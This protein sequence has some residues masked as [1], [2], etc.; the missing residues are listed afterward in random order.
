MGILFVG[1]VRYN[2]LVDGYI[3]I[4]LVG[5]GVWNIFVVVD[6]CLCED[7]LCLIFWVYGNGIVG[8]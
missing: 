4:V 6:V 8:E 3:V 7:L 2:V 1:E 5:K